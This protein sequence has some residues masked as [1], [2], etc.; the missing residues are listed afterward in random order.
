MKTFIAAT[1]IALG[2]IASPAMAQPGPWEML[3][4]SAPRSVFAEIGES[5][6]R[7]PFDQ[8]SESAPLAPVF[9]ELGAAAP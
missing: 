6:P 1:L 8:L 4:E 7:S 5:A 2:T 9:Q 3:N